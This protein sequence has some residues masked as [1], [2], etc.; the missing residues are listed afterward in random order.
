MP[1]NFP[2]SGF[3]KRNQGKK[4]RSSRPYGNNKSTYTIKKSRDSFFIVGT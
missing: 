1:E 3:M 2:D 4:K